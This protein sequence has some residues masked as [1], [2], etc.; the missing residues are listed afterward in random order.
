MTKIA[1]AD[2]IAP[3]DPAPTGTIAPADNG[4]PARSAPPAA[5]AATDGSL[6][7]HAGSPGTRPAPHRTRPIPQRTRPA[8]PAA[9][10]RL[11]PVSATLAANE[12]LSRRRQAGE[13][14]LP[15]AFGEAGLPAHPLLQQALAD[16]AAAAGG[17][18]YG[19]VAGQATL[20]AA[21]AGYWARRGLPTSPDDVVA[22]PGS[23]SLLFGLLLA[24]GADVAMPRP[25]WVSYAAQTALIGGAPHLVPVPPG[26]G[27]ICDP[28]RLAHAVVKARAAG[29]RI[30]A[31]I[32]TLPDNPT[33]RL[34]RPATVR[35]LAEVAAEYDLVI[36]ADEIYR[37]L[38]YDSAPPIVSP[39]RHAPERTV[40]TTALSKSLALGGWRI[41]VARLPAGPAGAALRDR[42]LGIGS[43][44]WSAT[45][46][47][48]QQAAALAFAEPPALTERIAGSRRLHEAVSRGVAA[49]FTEAGVDVPTPQAA[50]YLYPDFAP[51]RGHL[52]GRHGVTT[53]AGLARLLL[54]RYGMGTLPASAFGEDE[55]ALRL[56]VATGLLYGETDAE[57]EQ[58]LASPA[59]LSLPWIA[60]ALDRLTEILDDVAR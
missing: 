51:W 22:G 40:V 12:A 3:D 19:P 15:M 26:E 4:A 57:R 13:P 11:V 44:I 29:R 24:I 48:V 56:R 27:G 58:A 6:A 36:I 47:P 55:R 8:L 18:A 53:S 59:P 23:K 35:A 1:P 32:V 28:T 9:T 39:A 21:A 54:S 30:G 10:P 45:A 42:L 52:A 2:T 31:V 16:G 49:R 38:R 14:V 46:G 41:G 5:M 20:R 25:S 60:A 43:E 34:A 17:N 50:F 33:G 7:E 37:D